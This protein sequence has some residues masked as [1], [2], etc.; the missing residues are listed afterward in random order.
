MSICR[1]REFYACNKTILPTS[2]RR[3]RSPLFPAVFPGGSFLTYKERC[4]LRV[5][6]AQRMTISCG[7]LSPNQRT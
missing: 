4:L 2:G 5:R 6:I 7:E 1:G 3:L